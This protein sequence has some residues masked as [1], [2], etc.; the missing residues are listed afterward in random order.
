MPYGQ[1]FCP[2]GNI[3]CVQFGSKV[4]FTKMRK[5]TG[6]VCFFKDSLNNNAGAPTLELDEGNVFTF[7]QFEYEPS[8]SKT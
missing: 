5:K 2:N 1:P 3:Q 7:D 8:S 6:Y 4:E